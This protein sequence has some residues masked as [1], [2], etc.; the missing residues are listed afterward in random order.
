MYTNSSQIDNRD[1]E[2]ADVSSTLFSHYTT[3]EKYAKSFEEEKASPYLFN[4]YYIDL[5]PFKKLAL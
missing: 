3:E 2:V 4:D 1:T 5:G